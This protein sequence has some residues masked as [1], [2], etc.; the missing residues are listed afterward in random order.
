MIEDSRAAVLLV[1]EAL[2]KTVEPALSKMSWLKAVV[3]VGDKKA[4]AAGKI[5]VY[6]LDE[7]VARGKPELLPRRRFLTKSRSGFTRRARPVR[8]RA[9]STCIRA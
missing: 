4:L 8:R 7:V 5:A 2:A 6:S 9:R 3:V 1:S